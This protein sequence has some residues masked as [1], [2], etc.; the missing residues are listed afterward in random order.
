MTL[1]EQKAEFD[2][3]KEFRGVEVKYLHAGPNG[4]VQDIQLIRRGEVIAQQTNIRHRG[5]ITTSYF[6]P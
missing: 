2:R 1:N 5:K 4:K 3:R 6:L